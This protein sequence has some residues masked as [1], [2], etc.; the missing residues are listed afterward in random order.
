MSYSSP[1]NYYKIFD[2]RTF[3][4]SCIVKLNFLTP[5][6]FYFSE[7]SKIEIPRLINFSV[8]SWR[9]IK[10]ICYHHSN[11]DKS[12]FLYFKNF[13]LENAQYAIPLFECKKFRCMSCNKIHNGKSTKCCDMLNSPIEILD[14]KLIQIT[15][16]K[17]NEINE[18]LAYNR[19][20]FLKLH[21]PDFTDM[22]IVR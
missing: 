2:E 16:P 9:K 19:E 1:E 10:K 14:A 11:F 5:D 17:V 13:D 4:F 12:I 21:F 15:L 3:G 6:K 22:I 8:M 18:K 20:K 7:E